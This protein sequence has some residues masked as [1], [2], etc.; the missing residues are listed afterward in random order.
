MSMAGFLKIMLQTIKMETKKI[1]KEQL[2]SDGWKELEGNERLFFVME[3]K[4]ENRNPINASEDT[5]ISLI[6]HHDFNVPQLAILFPDGG[7]LNFNV[8][9]IE[10]LKQF[11]N[12][13]DFYDAS[14]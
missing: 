4:I 13:I 11:E 9:N 14:F 6:V 3:K 1:T 5:D 8:S 12:C 2:L 7:K 10:Q